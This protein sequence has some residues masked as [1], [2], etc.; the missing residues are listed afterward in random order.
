MKKKSLDK[1]ID[2]QY[3]DSENLSFED[4]TFHAVTAGFGVRNF[5]N[6]DKGLSEMCRVM[7]V[8]GKLAILELQ[9]EPKSFPLNNCM[10]FILKLYY[11]VLANFFK[12]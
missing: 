4:N 10:G 11:H 5:E 12:R 8:G 3:G 9:A 2:M 7:K 1:I 6:L